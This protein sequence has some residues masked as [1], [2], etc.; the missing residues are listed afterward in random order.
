MKTGKEI[1]LISCASSK[2]KEPAKAK[3]LYCSSLFIKSK[4]HAEKYFDEY[5]ILSAKHGLVDPDKIIGY[6][7]KTLNKMLAGERKKW[8]KNV[9]KSLKPLLGK[10]DKIV[11][12]AGKR[13]R[14]FLEKMLDENGISHEAPLKNLRIG[15]QLQRLCVPKKLTE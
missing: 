5:F 13:Y 6:Y 14:E 3:E 4:E 8:A 11:F 2:K 15:E 12:L 10:D 7:D 1:V 9:F